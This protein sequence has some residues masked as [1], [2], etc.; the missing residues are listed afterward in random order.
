MAE[1]ASGGGAA[2]LSVFDHVYVLNLPERTDR[3]AESAAQFRRIGL[4][5]D[6]PRITLFPAA[7]P[8]DKGDFPSIGTRGCFLS[9]MQV[10]E[11]ALAAGHARYLLMEDDADFANGFSDR[12]AA[13][14]PNLAECDWGMFYGWN[15]DR[16]GRPAGLG[17]LVEIPPDRGIVLAH[18][19]GF[20]AAA[21]ERILPFIAAI[22]ARP[23]GHPEGGAMHVDG[24]YTWFRRASP[25]M[26]TFAVTEA[27]SLQRSSRSDI[28]ALAWF[29]R[30]GPARPVADALRRIR[31][32][33][34]R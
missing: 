19:L 13:L 30:I 6:D 4:S 33:L 31:A 27:L 2:L 14:A 3:R 17:E 8:A 18:F 5:F 25:D 29:D 16:Y 10:H 12:M 22:Y 21:A 34:A 20:S 7:R 1:T 9:H 32:R 26:R 23:Y 15:P 28:H 11:A 24:A